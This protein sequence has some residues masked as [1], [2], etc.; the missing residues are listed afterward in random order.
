MLS[1][2]N[3]LIIAG[4]GNKSGKTTFACRIIEQFRYLDLASVK[5][6]PHFHE[7]TPGL[8]LLEG[9]KEYSLFEETNQWTQKDTSRMLRAGASKVYFANAAGS[10]ILEVVK[11]VNQLVRKDA[12]VIC[13]SP[14]LRNYVEPGLF[15]IMRSVSENN[16]KSI[17]NFLTLPHLE[18]DMESLSRSAKLP[19]QFSNGRWGLT[20]NSS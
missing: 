1:I 4:T 3:L 5:I 20:K 17:S 11:K 9:E 19:V 15:V 7:P 2:P 12:P 13:E 14:A 6:T 10:S 8:V 18:F 16:E